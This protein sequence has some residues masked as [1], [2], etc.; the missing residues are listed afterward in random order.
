MAARKQ[1]INHDYSSIDSYN[2]FW[3]NDSK[4]KVDANNTNSDERKQNYTTLVNQYY[5]LATDFYE[6]AWGTSFHF[7]P[8]RHGESVQASIARHEH[9]LALRLGLKPGMKVL[10]VG[11]GV[12]GPAMEIARFS[13]ASITG[14]NNNEY[15]VSRAEAHIKNAGLEGLINIVKGDFMHIPYPDDSFDAIYAIEAVCHAPDKIGIYTE[16][17][18]VMKP[19]ASFACYEWC[20]TDKFDFNNSEHRELKENIEV[21]DG[22][23]DIDSTQQVLDALRKVGFEIVEEKDLAVPDQINPIPWYD[24]FA[25][26]YFSLSGIKVTQ[27][28]INVTHTTLNVLEKVGLLTKGT[29]ATHSMLIRAQKGLVKGGRTGSFTPMYYFQVTKPLKSSKKN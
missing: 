2:K 20:L 6:W 16:L 11:C 26:S 8:R 7:A 19:G 12:A 28:G 13:G 15:Q 17:F 27:F 4:D 29:T 23:P 14:I 21:G 18:R 1:K 5:D 22:L 25:P 3:T 9:F 10:D 24:P